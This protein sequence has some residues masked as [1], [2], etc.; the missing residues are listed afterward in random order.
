MDFNKQS[1][2]NS[3][4]IKLAG[5]LALIGLASSIIRPSFRYL[6]IIAPTLMLFS[7]AKRYVER[8]RTETRTFVVL[9]VLAVR[10]FQYCYI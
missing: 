2:R 4:S 5:E 10:H 1:N 9:S 8:S 3:A 6:L 7:W